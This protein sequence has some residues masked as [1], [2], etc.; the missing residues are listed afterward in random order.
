MIGSFYPFVTAD[1]SNMHYIMTVDVV[2]AL[3]GL[4]AF[5]TWINFQFRH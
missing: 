2:S 4:A 3:S 1:A 5:F